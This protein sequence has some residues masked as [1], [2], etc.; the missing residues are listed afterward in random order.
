MSRVTTL[1]Q[2]LKHLH[3]ECLS[4]FVTYEGKSGFILILVNLSS[5]F[6]PYSFSRTILDFKLDMLIFKGQFYL[7]LLCV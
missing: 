5:S 4:A 3:V 7:F 1:S 6:Y 2:I